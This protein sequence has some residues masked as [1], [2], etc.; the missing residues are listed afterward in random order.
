MMVAQS[1]QRTAIA[2]RSSCPGRIVLPSDL[3][4]L[5]GQYQLRGF[6]EHFGRR[7]SG[8]RPRSAR[9]AGSFRRCSRPPTR[10]QTFVAGSWGSTGDRL[11]LSR[12]RAAG[13][14]SSPRE[15]ETETRDG[16]LSGDI[17]TKDTRRTAARRRDDPGRPQCRRAGVG[18]PQSDAG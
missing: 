11:K 2:I 1:V 7:G 17:H 18:H 8:S 5:A 15:L 10:Y 3:D 12:D 6:E 4:R 13:E 14:L 16:C 9:F